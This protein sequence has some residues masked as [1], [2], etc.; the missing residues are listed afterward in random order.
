MMEYYYREYGSLFYN[1]DLGFITC[2]SES[3]TVSLTE[4]VSRWGEVTFGRMAIP[5]G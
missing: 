3:R 4:D 2:N 1:K 5:L